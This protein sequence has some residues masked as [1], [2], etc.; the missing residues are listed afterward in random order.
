MVQT[1]G[2]RIQDLPLSLVEGKAFFTKELDRAL[3]DGE[4]DLAVHSF[5][6]VPTRLP[7]GIVLG[8]VLERGDPRD[9]LVGA[10]GATLAQLPAGSRIGTS[11]PRRRAFLLRA[12]PDL[13][14]VDLR[15]NVP[16]RVEVVASGRLDGAILALAGLVRLG[17]EDRVT[18]VLDPVAFV[19]A[20]AQ[21]AVAV[22]VRT[23]EAE[24]VAGL[25]HAATRA[26][27]L[28][29]RTVLRRLEGGCHAPLGALARGAEQLHL[30]AAVA[31]LDGSEV[32][33]ERAAGA[34]S[35][36]ER[37]GEALAE[38]LLA[39]GAARLVSARR[40]PTERVG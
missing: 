33:E 2:D 18:D 24:A 30:H 26:A 34:A 21:G 7:D 23:G 15:G 6:D 37:L 12:R 11:S 1:A 9:A 25:D 32:L 35:D 19:P 8:A 13:V 27:A 31:A 10:G 39:G 40:G 14:P 29:E 20:P 16:T 36:P 22:L 28:A 38:R 5:K 3:L 17:L 4:I